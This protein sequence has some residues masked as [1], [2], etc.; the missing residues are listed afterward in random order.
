[1]DQ[2]WDGQ[3]EDRLT[4]ADLVAIRGRWTARNAAPGQDL[5]TLNEQFR[6]AQSDLGRLLRYVKAFEG[7]P[8]VS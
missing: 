3:I 5:G 4:E 7:P 6:A 2:E 1:M 8:I